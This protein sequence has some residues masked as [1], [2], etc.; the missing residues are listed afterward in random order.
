M[1]SSMTPREQRGL[2]IAG[3]QKLTRKGKIWMVPSQT[4]K[5]TYTVLPDEEEP[6][7][8]CPDFQETGLPCK[9]VFAVKFTMTRDTAPDGTVTV[10]QTVTLT[11]KQT[12]KQDWPLYNFGQVEEKRRFLVLL[13]DLCQGLKD[14]APN[15]TGR[16]RTPMADVVFTCALKVYTRL[17][18]RRFG[19]D[20]DEAFEKGFLSH[21]IHPMMVCAFLENPALT[22]VLKHLVSF[23]ALPLRAVETE[24]AVDSTGFSASRFVRYYD[25]K[26]GAER[27][28]KTWVKCHMACGTRTHC[29]T[30][31]EVLHRD[32]ADCPQFKPL[33]DKT[34]EGF[35][36]GEVSADKAYLS[37]E[38][39]EA[40]FAHGGM[41]YI[42]FKDNSTGA[43]GGLF[44]KMYHYYS[45]NREEYMAHYHKRSN[46]ESANSMIKAKFGDSVR[47]KD[48]VAMVNEALVKI[49]CHNLCCL[50][51]SQI[52]LGIAPVFWGEEAAQDTKPEPAPVVVPCLEPPADRPNWMPCA[53]A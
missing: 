14:P 20:L 2:A 30:A 13:H 40:V 11:Q 23:S 16:P 32:A 27:S 33:V 7:C 38:N 28:G 6:Y 22:P 4:G 42:A 5:G 25:E 41:P 35:T 36:V 31:V 29:V 50:I 15:K 44:E 43:A 9:H 51:S 3:S 45:L 47:S 24:F 37:A 34:A 46:I 26:Y 48:D 8:N 21:K 12:Y 1:T 49:V 10:V 18:S 53:G 19:T 39:I 17:S 52:E